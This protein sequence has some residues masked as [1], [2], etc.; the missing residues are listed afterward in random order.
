MLAGTRYDLPAI[1]FAGFERCCHLSVARIEDLAQQKAY[2]FH[3]RER[4]K[5]SQESQRKRFGH[6]HGLCS[7]R[8]HQRL[9]QPGPHVRFALPVRRF[10]S[11]KSQPRY[12][13][14]EV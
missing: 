3:R 11:V 1:G 7:D 10:Q 6:F 8:F 5:Q 4:F 14:R 9:R 13:R 12:Y 2:T